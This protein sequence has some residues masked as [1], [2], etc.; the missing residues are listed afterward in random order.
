MYHLTNEESWPYFQ[1]AMLTGIGVKS[2]GNYEGARTE[3]ITN[4]VLTA[5]GVGTI[6]ELRAM[7]VQDLTSNVWTNAENAYMGWSIGWSSGVGQPTDGTLPEPGTVRSYQPEGA[8]QPIVDGNTYT[9][10]T[11]FKVLLLISTSIPKTL[12]STR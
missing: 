9:D 10:Y 3:Y 7:S 12:D 1:R 4:S 2:S 8:Y 6:D 11:M 5:A